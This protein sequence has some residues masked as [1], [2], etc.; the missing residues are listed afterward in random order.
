MTNEMGD[1]MTESLLRFSHCGYSL[2]LGIDGKFRYNTSPLLLR[3]P[4]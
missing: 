2:M 3:V 4:V 1:L